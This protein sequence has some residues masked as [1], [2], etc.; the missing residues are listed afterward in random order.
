MVYKDLDTMHTYCEK[1][2]GTD[3]L[4][5]FVS[6]M[7]DKYKKGVKYTTS[8]FAISQSYY[9]WGHDGTY[10]GMR[11]HEKQWCNEIIHFENLTAGLKETMANH[12]VDFDFTEWYQL[13]SN[14]NYCQNLNVKKFTRNALDLM[15]EV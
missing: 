11:N 8:G 10:D 5:T 9:I 2:C 6:T 12:H 15:A 13:N 4:D 14:S 3:G 7:L 1:P